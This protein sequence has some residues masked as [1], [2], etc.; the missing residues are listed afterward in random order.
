MIEQLKYLLDKNDNKLDEMT[1][2]MV[3]ILIKV[4]KD[5]TRLDKEIKKKQRLPKAKPKKKGFFK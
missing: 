1:K 4:D 3:D 5:I 2:L